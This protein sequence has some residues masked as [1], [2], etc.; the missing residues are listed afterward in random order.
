MQLPRLLYACFMIFFVFGTSGCRNEDEK[1][2]GMRAFNRKVKTFLNDSVITTEE[3]TELENIVISSEMLSNRFGDLSRLKSHLENMAA[4]LAKSKRSDITLPID[5]NCPDFQAV[6]NSGEVQSEQEDGEEKD[7]LSF[8]FYIENSGSMYGYLNDNTAFKDV[9][10]GLMTKIDRY[11]EPLN[12]WFV[13]D[14]IYPATDKEKDL[15]TPVRETFDHFIKYLNPQSLSNIG[16]VKNSNLTDVLS[17]VIKKA[18]E[19]G[20]P[21]ILFSD[22]IFSIGNSSNVRRELAS[23]EHGITL[24]IHDNKLKENGVGFLLMKFTSKFT[25]NYYTYNNNRI[26]LKEADRPYYVWVI[27]KAGLLE[28]FI[29]KYEVES[30]NGYKNHVNIFSAGES[31]GHYSILRKTNAKGRFNLV[32]RG[33]EVIQAIED[34]EYSTRNGKEFQFSVAVDL[35]KLS[36]SEEYLSNKSNWTVKTEYEDP[37]VIESIRKISLKD[38]DNLDRRYLGDANYLITLHTESLNSG[39]QDLTLTLSKK[40]PQ[41]INDSST[42]NDLNMSEGS[43]NLQKTFGFE[44][45]VRGVWE[46]YKPLGGE[47]DYYFKIHLQL[48]R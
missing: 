5:F 40:L 25:G 41:W 35:S 32:E 17:M 23:Q 44:D 19:D 1:D 46:D 18:A 47:E 15:A 42:D 16:N 4:Q 36:L 7:A 2:D 14:A 31:S 6:D 26:P 22:F 28:E 24:V 11:D 38:V 27:G 8:N 12:L 48:E 33:A 21:A 39:K 43:S 9:I 10:L 45:L 20:K 3:C 13:N 34:I 29:Q 30:L 37:F